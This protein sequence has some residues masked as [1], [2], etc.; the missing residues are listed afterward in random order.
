MSAAKIYELHLRGGGGD[1]ACD[2]C[3]VEAKRDHKG[4]VV[5]VALIDDPSAYCM[6]CG[7]GQELGSPAFS[8]AFSPGPR[9]PGNEQTEAP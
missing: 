7:Y 1:H 2:E 6:W 5:S 9:V 3:L 8:N 4:E